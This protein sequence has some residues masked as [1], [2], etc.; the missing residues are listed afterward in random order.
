MLVQ[1]RDGRQEI[2]N[3]LK[4]IYAVSSA[5]KSVN[6]SAC[7]DVAVDVQNQFKNKSLVLVDEIHDAVEKSLMKVDTD[8]AK[9]YILYRQKRD[10]FRKATDPLNAQI[11][12]FYSQVNKDNANAA[13]GSAA[14][15]MYSIAEAATK[16]YNLATMSPKFAQNHRDGKIYIHDLGYYGVTFNCFFNPIRDMLKNGFNNGVGYIRPPKRIA[17]AVALVAIILQSSQNDMFGGQGVL[18]FDS[19]LAPYVDLELAFQRRS[20]SGANP[21]IDLDS[22]K[23]LAMKRTDDAVFQAMEAFVY[24]MNTMRSRS[25]CQVTFSSVNF[26]TDSSWQARLI[27]K[28]LFKAYI[29]G[30]GKGENPIFPNLCY[31]LKKGIN[32]Y[33]GDPNFDLTQLAIECVG[34]R[35]QPRFVF[36]DSPAYQ[37]LPINHI[38]TMGCLPADEVITYQFNGLTRCEGIGR[39]FDRLKVGFPV[40]S[41]GLSDFFIPDGLKIWDRDDFVDVKTVIRNPKSQV[42]HVSFS[43]GRSI[44]ATLDHPFYVRNKGRITLEHLQIGDEILSDYSCPDVVDD[45]LHFGDLYDSPELQYILGVLTIGGAF[46]DMVSISN[47]NDDF[48][49]K[50]HQCIDLICNDGNFVNLREK[51]VPLNE[52]DDIIQDSKGGLPMISFNSCFKHDFLAGVID[53]KGLSAK[54]KIRINSNNKELLLQLAWLLQSIEIPANIYPTKSK[55]VRS[56]EFCPSVKLLDALAR[57]DFK[58]KKYTFTETPDYI[59]VTSIHAGG[60]ENHVYDVETATDH[61]SVSLIQSG[62]CR[63]AIRSNV[64]GDASPD[65]RGNLAFNTINLPYVALESKHLK[66]DFFDAL[67]SAVNDAIDELLERYDVIANLKPQD[68]PFVGQWYQNHDENDDTIENMVKNGTLSVGFIG[69]AECLKVLT[70]KHH[71]ESESAQALGLEI[72]SYI[73]NAT[74]NAT[75][76]FGLNFSTFATPAESACYT[77][78]KKCRKRFGI[79]DGVTDKKYLTNS[80][81]LPVSFQCDAKTKI[82]IESPYHLLCNAGAIFYIETG[83]SPA[84]NPDGVLKMLQYISKSGIVYGGLN[85]THAFCQTCNYQGSFVDKCPVCGSDDIKETKIITGYLSEVNRFNDGKLAEAGDRVAHAG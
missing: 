33:E 12:K 27:T 16:Q 82:D 41:R 75:K 36:C 57:T 15:K 5:M 31:R 3:A 60:Y 38:G 26:G 11:A 17:S 63:T 9:N 49:Q 18:N 68:V 46:D 76:K 50:L 71:G 8:A 84:V 66:I 30:L 54:G 24:N 78:L 19:D 73:R 80:F 28:N 77:L 32:L 48:I 37:N 51:L 52:L 34:K 72:I 55:N 29:A 14:S 20:I 58:T 43:N 47:R 65:A 40:Q 42:Y 44:D 53:F 23:R 2:F 22:L 64:N 83:A 4:I 10:D 81:H 7:A 67:N 59:K 70:G 45:S 56:I 25:G 74:D 79:I 35:I 21:N 13:N 62:N 1:K 69:L 61:F 85:W 6:W 39:M